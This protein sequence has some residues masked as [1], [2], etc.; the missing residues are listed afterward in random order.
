MEQMSNCLSSDPW[1]HISVKTPRCMHACMYSCM[2]DLSKINMYA[3]KKIV[4][5]NPTSP[6]LQ[7]KVAIVERFD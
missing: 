4:T 5:L 2:H 6:P 1:M 3:V 7:A